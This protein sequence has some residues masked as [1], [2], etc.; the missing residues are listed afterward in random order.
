MK[1]M[2][3]YFISQRYES[4]YVSIINVE[5]DIDH[6]SFDAIHATHHNPSIR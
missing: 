2:S 6:A 5:N 1:A 3:S 4:D